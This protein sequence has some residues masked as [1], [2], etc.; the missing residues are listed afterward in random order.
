MYE[1]YVGIIFIF[2]NQLIENNINI[3]FYRSRYIF[4]SKISISIKYKST[5]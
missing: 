2:I 3:F 5:C 4:H 1:K